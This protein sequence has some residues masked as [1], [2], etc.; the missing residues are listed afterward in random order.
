MRVS[1]WSEV[2]RKLEKADKD[3]RAVECRWYKMSDRRHPVHAH[4]HV[5]VV[6]VEPLPRVKVRSRSQA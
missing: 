4:G 5:E 6:A 2:V 3:G 1:L